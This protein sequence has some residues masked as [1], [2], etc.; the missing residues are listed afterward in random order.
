MNK[1]LNTTF[2]KLVNLL[3]D[4]QYHDGTTLGDVLSVTRSAVWKMIKKLEHY[5]V[6]IDSVK[7]KGYALSQPL[8]LLDADAIKRDCYQ[9]IDIHLFESV[10]STN[11]YLKTINHKN[12]MT[13]CLAEQQTSGRGRFHREWYSPFAKNIYVSCLYSFQKDVSELSGLSLVMSL[14]IVKTLK[15]FGIDEKC[16]V[17]W[18]NDILYDTKKISGS[19]IE[20]QA[21][22]HG[23]MHAIIGIGINVNML[24]HEAH[25]IPQAWSSMQQILNR[26]VNRNEVCVSLLN[27]LF[28]YLQKFAEQG[29]APFV[30]EWKA[31]DTLLDQ[32]IALTN[33]NE[34]V[35]GRAAGIENQ[36]RLLLQ[37]EGGKIRAFSSGDTSVVKGSVVPSPPTL[38][39]GGEG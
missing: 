28:D 4:G 22:T 2:V 36:G 37:L 19:L 17:K 1:K 35:L 12:Q 31:V 10:D 26:Y 20:I 11:A 21:E 38:L 27:N 8:I 33:G 25:D 3:S 5:Q 7:G 14:A 24:Q 13:V 23:A 9:A 18:P 34:T 30:S 16:G 32:C 29:L 15:A 39:I 6:K